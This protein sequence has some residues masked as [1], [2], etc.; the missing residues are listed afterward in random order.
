MRTRLKT[1]HD[2]RKSQLNSLRHQPQKIHSIIRFWIHSKEH[3]P[4]SEADSF[5]SSR[6]IRCAVWNRIFTKMSAY[7]GTDFHLKCLL[8][9]ALT[10]TWPSTLQ[11][12]PKKRITLPH[13]IRS[14]KWFLSF[15]HS[16]IH[17][18]H[19]SGIHL[20]LQ[21]VEAVLRYAVLLLACGQAATT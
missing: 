3:S 16:H 7:S 21:H 5:L 11:S 13:I 8:I 1:R 17:M 10:S 6:E 14:I 9:L 19:V 15:I 18:P 12:I 2:K 20:L 4:S